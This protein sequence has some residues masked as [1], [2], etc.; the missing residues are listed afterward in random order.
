MAA[1]GDYSVAYPST[2]NDQFGKHTPNERFFRALNS[3]PVNCD[4]LE[5]GIEN[6]DTI[7]VTE[8]FHYDVRYDKDYYRSKYPL[9]DE[10]VYN[11]LEWSSVDKLEE[12]VLRYKLKKRQ[13][14]LTE[15]RELKKKLDLMGKRANAK[16]MKKIR[17]KFVMTFK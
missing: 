14:K 6:S 10:A 16:K 12:L 7:P 8:M 11:I 5:Y 4:Y 13:E 15:R 3:N 1:K 9:F 2:F 17:R